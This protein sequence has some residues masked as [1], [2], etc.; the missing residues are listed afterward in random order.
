MKNAP[1]LLEKVPDF[2]VMKAGVVVISCC[3][4]PKD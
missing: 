4:I 3:S 1:I 2:Q